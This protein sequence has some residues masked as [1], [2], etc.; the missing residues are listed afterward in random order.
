[1]SVPSVSDHSSRRWPGYEQDRT[2]A[3]IDDHPDLAAELS[4][5][6]PNGPVAKVAIGSD[7]VA[8]RQ[9]SVGRSLSGDLDC[10]LFGEPAHREGASMRR[11]RFIG[12]DD[13]AEPDTAAQPSTNGG[14]CVPWPPHHQVAL[15][16]LVVRIA[17]RC[18]SPAS[19]I[20]RRPRSRAGSRF[21]FSPAGRSSTAGTPARL[22]AAPS[23]A[24]R[25]RSRAPA[26]T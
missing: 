26:R 20:Q 21:V 23:R 25:W 11:T 6:G 2:A 12:T 18:Q 16:R 14:M 3:T 17:L 5:R 19:L 13:R 1:M 4:R 24:A 10:P 8:P 7:R 22:R 9:A 15:A